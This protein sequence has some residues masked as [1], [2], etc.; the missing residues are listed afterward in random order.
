MNKF[1]N[2]PH[3]TFLLLVPVLLL[4]GFYNSEES[5]VVNIHDSYYVMSLT[6]LTNTLSILFG[7]IGIGYWI[8]N[9][10]NLRLINWLSF[11]HV[12]LTQIG[13][14]IVFI[15]SQLYQ[16]SILKAD[17]NDRLTMY[18][19]ITG[20]IVLIGQIIFPINLINGILN[21][22]KKTSG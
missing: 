2:Y 22:R 11:I 6:N 15:L 5:L 9:I 4:Y 12:R 1:L 7:L 8:M 19:L 16:K 18:I 14:G 17:F 10:K 20:I 13:I 3:V 21:K